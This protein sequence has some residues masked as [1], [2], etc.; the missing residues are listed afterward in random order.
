M[1]SSAS[2]AVADSTVHSTYAPAALAVLTKPVPLKPPWSVST[3]A[4]ALKEAF[5][6]SYRTGVP[7]CGVAR[8]SRVSPVA[9]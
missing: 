5:S 7:D 8:I 2:R 1:V 3:V 4:P 6:A 9:G